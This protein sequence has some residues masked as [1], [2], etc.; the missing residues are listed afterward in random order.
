LTTEQH[1]KSTVQATTAQL[2]VVKAVAE[3]PIAGKPAPQQHGTL[4]QLPEPVRAQWKWL[5]AASILIAVVTAVTATAYLPLER[6]TA[7]IRAPVV[8]S[9][10][11]SP[12]TIGSSSRPAL[13]PDAT[14][15][16]DARS[17]PDT[18]AQI[19]NLIERADRLVGRGDLGAAR[20]LYERAVDAG[21]ARAA[22]YLGTTYDPSFLSRARLGKSVRGD[23]DT[24][25][26]WYRRARDLGSSEAEALLKTS[27]R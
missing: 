20:L 14:A 9:T 10:A 6:A 4:K 8:T 2:D 17:A 13:S 21:D 7:S 27:V 26:Y 23:L 22:I 15:R 12:S 24:A 25:A 11:E 19:T 1:K 16:P 5:I 18:A 3:K